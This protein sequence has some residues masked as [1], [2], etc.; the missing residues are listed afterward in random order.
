MQSNNS[1]QSPKMRIM[2]ETD[3][4]LEIDHPHLV[5]RLSEDYLG[6]DVKGSFKDKVEEALGSTPIL[7]DVFD[8]FVPLHVRLCDMDLARI[9]ETG[10]VKIAL[11][12]RRDITLPLGADEAKRL[13]DKLN[14]LIPAAKAR[15]LELVIRAQALN[16][17]EMGVAKRIS[18]SRKWK[19]NK[20]ADEILKILSIELPLRKDAKL[21]TANSKRIVATMGSGAK[22]RLWGRGWL[23]KEMLPVKIILQMNESATETIVDA[24]IQDN[25]DP[26]YFIR[27]GL[28]ERYM[29]YMQD[30]FDWLSAILEAKS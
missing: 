28:T 13:V 15:E 2:P 6:I 11:R 9:E 5:I 8:L 24:T 29:D 4:I 1:L 26:F 30:L 14:E 22:T 12:H 3:V 21:L 27:A 7:K 17:M 10:K 23:S 19:V 18:D 25:L 20:S 16:P